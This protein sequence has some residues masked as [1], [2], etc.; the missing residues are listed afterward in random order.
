M[1][2]NKKLAISITK[3]NKVDSGQN[4][5]IQ[6]SSLLTFIMTSLNYELDASNF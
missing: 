5:S 6:L 3:K 1:K 2:T 4:S